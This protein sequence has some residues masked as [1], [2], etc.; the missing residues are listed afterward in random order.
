VAITN[1]CGPDLL[2]PLNDGVFCLTLV[3]AALGE[4]SAGRSLFEPGCC[5]KRTAARAEERG[6]CSCLVGSL[7]T[8]RILGVLSGLVSTSQ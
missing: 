1:L 3:P 6:F 8:A 5:T 7:A 4:G 2:T